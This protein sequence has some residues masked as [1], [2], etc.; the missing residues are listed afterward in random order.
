MTE[1][2]TETSGIPPSI[3]HAPLRVREF[4]GLPAS[5]PKTPSEVIRELPFDAYVSYCDTILAANNDREVTNSALLAKLSS[6]H[7]RF[8]GQFVIP[9]LR[10]LRTIDPN[11]AKRFDAESSDIKWAMQKPDP[12]VNFKVSWINDHAEELSVLY[13]ETSD[14]EIKR[15]IGAIFMTQLEHFQDRAYNPEIRPAIEFFISNF[16]TFKDFLLP[17][18]SKIFFKKGILASN[19]SDQDLSIED[20][21]DTARDVLDIAMRVLNDPDSS[22]A[23]VDAAYQGLAVGQREVDNPNMVDNIESFM[24]YKIRGFGLNANEILKVW[25]YNFFKDDPGVN[26]MYPEFIANNFEIMQRLEKER[27]GICIVLYREFGIHNFSRYPFRALVDQYDNKDRN[28]PY[29]VVIYPHTDKN[30]GFSNDVSSLD[31][32]YKD[33]LG[34]KTAM[35]IYEAGSKVGVAR[36]L[37]SVNKKYGEKN[38]I[39][40][41]ILGGHGEPDSMELGHS[42]EKDQD[43]YELVSHTLSKYDLGANSPKGLRGRFAKK[44]PKGATI[45]EL[46]TWFIDKPSIVL[47]SCSTGA[48]AGIGN[49]I[50]E[51]GADVI[52]PRFPAHLDRLA[53]GKRTNGTLWFSVHFID[54]DDEYK[55]EEIYRHFRQ[56]VA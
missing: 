21:S 52:A 43:E 50:Y 8:D 45:S 17:S 19:H 28:L 6:W 31:E 56:K 51:M 38:K 47:V 23:L 44:D 30:G 25:S 3:R 11:R 33:L 1:V 49:E 41:A 5:Q 24:A 9:T 22:W 18:H 37:V 36:R 40:F 10:T 13:G 26:R 14:E 54:P 42:I 7:P 46:K 53:A 55:P 34:A 20:H 16:D 2:R 4:F 48:D 29:G 32:V 27:Q 39:S 35:R 15:E 12:I